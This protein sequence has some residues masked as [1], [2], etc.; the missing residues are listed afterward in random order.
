M[1]TQRD[2]LQYVKDEAPV[3][4]AGDAWCSSISAP[5]LL[6]SQSDQFGP[7]WYNQSTAVQVARTKFHKMVGKNLPH[8]RSVM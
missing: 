1:L 7:S 6:C 3:P 8:N 4:L 2:L 5:T